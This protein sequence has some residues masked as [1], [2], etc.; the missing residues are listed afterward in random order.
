MSYFW[1]GKGGVFLDGC[2]AFSFFRYV[3]F[4]DSIKKIK[5]VIDISV[6]TDIIKHVRQQKQSKREV[7]G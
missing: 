6:Y 3:H 1:H 4:D 2:A 7:A 5:F